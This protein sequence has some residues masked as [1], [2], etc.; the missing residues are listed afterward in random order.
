MLKTY[1]SFALLFSLQM[2]FFQPTVNAQLTKQVGIQLVYD[3]NAFTNY[4]QITDYST[5]LSWY[6]AQDFVGGDNW[7]HRVFYNG[8]ANLYKTYSRRF[9][10]YHTLGYATAVSPLGQGDILSLGAN[11]ALNRRTEYYEYSNY[12]QTI[13]FI[14][15]KLWPADKFIA[16]AGYRARFRSYQNLPELSHLEHHLF[17]RFSYFL[18][19]KTSLIASMSFGIK[20]Y[21][22]YTYQIE[23]DEAGRGRR[24]STTTITEDN[25]TL[26][27]LRLGLKIGQA[28]ANGTGL[29]LFYLN[30]INLGQQ[31]YFGENQYILLFKEEDIFDDPYSYGGF[32]AGVTVTK[33]LPWR[34]KS[35]F[36]FEYRYKEYSSQALDLAGESLPGEPLRLDRRSQIWL[37]VA[38]TFPLQNTVQNVSVL[39]RVLYMLNRSNDQF[40]DYT[41]LLI[42]TGL[43]FSF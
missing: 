19:S 35:S 2:L 4:S 9:S 15:Y 14:N 31:S 23:T 26:R 39:F 27:Q 32:D 21:K 30:R 42:A 38:R 8:F 7:E 37:T 11:L 13:A 17:S 10:H 20:N 3:D 16:H 1:I 18:P 28:I 12:S 36:G 41:N 5:E 6:V 22:P 43:D 34:V 33:L 40:F 29:S 25:A 24:G